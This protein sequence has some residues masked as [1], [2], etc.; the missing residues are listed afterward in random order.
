MWLGR[1]RVTVAGTAPI[2][3]DQ[4]LSRLRERLLAIGGTVETECGG[5]VIGV[6][7]AYAILGKGYLLGTWYGNVPFRLRIRAT[8]ETHSASSQVRIDCDLTA[9]LV[10]FFCVSLA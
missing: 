2:S 1:T 3:F 5:T 8:S 9:A 7:Q 10:R 4:A 6:A